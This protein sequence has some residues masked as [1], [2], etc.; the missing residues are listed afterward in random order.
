MADHLFALGGESRLSIDTTALRLT[1]GDRV[2]LVDCSQITSVSRG[3]TELIIT[4]RE[5]D[6]LLVHAT[7]LADARAIEQ[8]LASCYGVSPLRRRRWQPETG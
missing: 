6:P 2:T 1:V 8:A 4:R 5:A 3:G 7:S